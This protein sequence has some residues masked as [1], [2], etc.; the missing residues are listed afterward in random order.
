MRAAHTSVHTSWGEDGIRTHCAAIRTAT[1]TATAVNTNES[2]S[3]P[4]CHGIEAQS[5]VLIPGKGSPPALQRCG[6][7][8]CCNFTKPAF[9]TVAGDSTDLL[10]MCTRHR[11]GIPHPFYHE[12]MA[13]VC[14]QSTWGLCGV[15]FSQGAHRGMQTCRVEIQTS[16]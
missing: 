7:A 6:V 13:G 3:I 2:L 4:A 1:A 5:N 15:P 10:C 16:A 14:R 8:Q 12:G 11:W 9:H